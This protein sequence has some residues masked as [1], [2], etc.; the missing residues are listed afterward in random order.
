MIKSTKTAYPM[1]GGRGGGAGGTGGTGGRGRGEGGGEE[2]REEDHR[3]NYYA[4]ARQ[5]DFKFFRY[6]C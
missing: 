1:W 6:L 4:T 3:V 5:R 2:R